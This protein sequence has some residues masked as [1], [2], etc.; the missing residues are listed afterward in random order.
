MSK[1]F[2][3]IAAMVLCAAPMVTSAVRAAETPDEIP[4]K[5]GEIPPAP[6]DAYAWCLVT[7]PPVYKTVTERV[8]VQPASFYYEVVPAKYE[9]V[10]EQVM[11]QAEQ[12]IATVV[13]AEYKTEKVTKMIKEESTRLEVVP[14]QYE[15]VD[16][17]VLAV[18]E[19]VRE[20]VIP[21]KYKTETKQILIS[22]AHVEWVEH[23]CSDSGAKITLREVKDKC[24][25]L[26]NV[27]AEYK[28]VSTTVMEEEPKTVKTVIPAQYKTIKVQKVVKPAQTVTVKIPAEFAEVEQQV[29]AKPATVTYSTIPA[30]YE[31]VKKFKLVEPESKKKMEIPAKYEEISHQVLDQAAV[32]VWRKSC[33]PGPVKAPK[34]RVQ[35]VV[36]KLG[37]LPGRAE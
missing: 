17:Q 11:V 26:I 7:K 4:F 3:K 13:P 28:T 21:A 23:D 18:A 31:T 32:R 20:E 2:L 9:T 22:E 34:S 27:P 16:E 33:Q 37:D 25:K 14:A 35:K 10:E 6:G 5:E 12:K 15:L 30:K 29:I 36:E 24:Y 19:G 1:G 8:L